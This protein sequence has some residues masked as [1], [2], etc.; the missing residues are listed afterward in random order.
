MKLIK[1]SNLNAIKFQI[2]FSL[3]IKF[4]KKNQPEPGDQYTRVFYFSRE[5][6]RT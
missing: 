5:K 6:D 2:T 4:I 3:K 1:K